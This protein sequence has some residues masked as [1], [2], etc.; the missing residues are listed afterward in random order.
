MGRKFIMESTR[1]GHS[2]KNVAVTIVLAALFQRR[3]RE[4]LHR[5]EPVLGRHTKKN[6][7]QANQCAPI[8]LSSYTF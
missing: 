6:N 7:T 5:E 4:R 8:T 3:K 2:R 1:V